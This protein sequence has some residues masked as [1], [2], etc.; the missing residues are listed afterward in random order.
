MAASKEYH[1]TSV[2]GSQCNTRIPA[3]IERTADGEVRGV[4]LW[5]TA[6]DLQRFGLTPDAVEA[7]VPQI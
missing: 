7:V 2:T 1:A 6:S 5:L 4:P 3:E